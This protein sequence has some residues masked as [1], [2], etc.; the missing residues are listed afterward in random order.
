MSV[1][2]SLSFS[3]CFIFAFISFLLWGLVLKNKE[4]DYDLTLFAW[5]W[6]CWGGVVGFMGLR[7]FL[8]GLGFVILDLVFALVDQLF[9]AAGFILLGYYVLY[10]TTKNKKVS[11]ILTYTTFLPASLS[12]LFFMF[13]YM[14]Q[15]GASFPMPLER[16]RYLIKSQRVVSEW[17]SEFI[18]PQATMDI[19]YLLV[20]VF[21]VFL[22]YELAIQ[23]ILLKN[24][25]GKGSY[26][27]LSVLSLIVFIIALLFDQKG[28][29]AGWHLLL[30]RIS[31]ITSALIAY[32]ACTNKMIF[33]EQEDIK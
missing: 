6:F 23:I 29:N 12:T 13:L 14:Q 3:V 27:F 21:V 4:K 22:A 19:I 30:I 11:K 31:A 10:R 2:L 20:F 24:K 15:K 5:L 28:T 18:P 33:E 9:L 25:K 32:L 17:G 7:T 8:F 26:K 16:L 1:S